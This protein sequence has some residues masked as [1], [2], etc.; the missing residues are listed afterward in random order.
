MMSHV[1]VTAFSGVQQSNKTPDPSL[2]T[3]PETTTPLV[4][5]LVLE[6]SE[7]V[8]LLYRNEAVAMTMFVPS[9]RIAPFEPERTC[10]VDLVQIASAVALALTS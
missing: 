1:S 4:A 6:L 2:V 9:L 8:V 3:V 10:S 7:N 5:V